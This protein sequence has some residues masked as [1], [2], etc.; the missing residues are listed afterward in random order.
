MAERDPVID[1][2]LRD[3]RVP[4]SLPARLAASVVFDDTAIDRTINDVALPPGLMDRLRTG[5]R[6]AASHGGGA[7][8][9]DRVHTVPASENG[10]R[11]PWHRAARRAAT[12]GRDALTVGC[13]LVCGWL[14][15]A[16]GQS[17][18]TRLA[19]SPRSPE[20]RP[21]RAATTAID[22]AVA[23]Q[24]PRRDESPL[25]PSAA[26]TPDDTLASAVISA[27]VPEEDPAAEFATVAPAPAAVEVRGAAVGVPAPSPAFPSSAPLMP[28]A[29]GRSRFVPRVAGFDLAFEMAHGESPFVDPAAAG[30]ATD[31]PPLVVATDSFD[32]L[33][34]ASR[35][36]AWRSLKTEHVF[37]AIDVPDTARPRANDVGLDIR[38]IRSLR[39]GRDAPT[40]LVEV[41]ATAGPATAAVAP[42]SAVVVLDRCGGNSGLVWTSLCRGLGG[43]GRAMAEHDRLTVVVAGPVPRIAVRS[44]DAAAI[45]QVAVELESLPPT[46]VADLDAAMVLAEPE[47]GGRLLVACHADT[48]DRARHAAAAAVAAWRGDRAAGDD[49]PGLAEG[50]DFVLI[51]PLPAASAGPTSLGRTPSDASSIR[52]A[53]LRR[54]F[55]DA[56]GVARNLRLEVAFDPR[57]VAAYRLIGHRQS[58][59]DSLDHTPAATIDLDA[60]E[61]AR[62]V[63]EVVP[64]GR[65][66]DGMISANATWQTVQDGAPRRTRESFDAAD[67]DLTAALPSPHGCAVLLA[68]ALGEAASGSPHADPRTVSRALAVAQRGRSRGDLPAVAAAA[69]DWLERYVADTR[70]SP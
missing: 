15:F 58:A 26:P 70:R 21:L 50:T 32:R 6:T 66:V 4:S 54:L 56:A 12:I 9:L 24:E 61:T 40:I 52:R 1:A 53:M 39:G 41:A 64:R 42:R 62:V 34:F 28:V 37:A 30:L 10:R 65:A 46:D 33:R 69:A 18:S 63:Y 13:A 67:A 47:A 49:A 23:R 14:F 17:L 57:H 3:V 2:R 22:G 60:G 43:V 20:P 35:R 11:N 44:G 36:S 45:R 29:A 51:D 16:A 55:G 8:D 27:S 19:G 7:L 5:G 31:V 25:G 68:A 59:V 38:G 48:A